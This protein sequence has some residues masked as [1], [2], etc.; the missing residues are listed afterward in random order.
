MIESF[1]YRT[2]ICGKSCIDLVLS[3]SEALDR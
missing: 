2:W 3:R 1:L